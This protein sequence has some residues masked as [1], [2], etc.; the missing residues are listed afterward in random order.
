MVGSML[1]NFRCRIGISLVL[2]LIWPSLNAVADDF[3]DRNP[4]APHQRPAFAG[5]TRAAVI[6]DTIELDKTLIAKGLENP[7]GMAQL[8][9]GNWL[10]TER[11]GR[12]RYIT[13]TGTLF[14]P[15]TG[16]PPVDARGQGG[17]LDV[18][19]DADFKTSRR[20]WWSFA[21]PRGNGKNATAVASGILSDDHRSLSD[22]KVIFR[23]NPA[24]QSTYHFG[25]RLVFDKTG[26]L[27]ITTG[28][29]SYP[30]ARILAQD[31]RTHIGKV[32]RITKSGEAAPDNPVS[33]NF[34]PEI[35]SYG[36]RNIQAA[37]LDA[38]GRLWTVEHGPRG[39]DEL[40]RPEAHKNYGWPVITY[41]E[42][43]N[44]A[45]LGEGRTADDGMEQ[46]VYYWDP[47][48]APSGMAFY[49]GDM[50]P[51]W[52]GSALIGGLASRSLVRI[53]MKD[54]RVIGEA[55]Y[56]QGQARIRDVKIGQ[57]GAVYILSDAQNG[58]LI[59]LTPKNK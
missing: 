36:H 39:G 37:A 12:L 34:L 57:D 25:S 52:R 30:E 13:A 54:D 19:I 1:F 53:I 48:I 51:S 28:E 16:L 21:E 14:A 23:Q 41:G 22:V 7:W 20:L 15:I 44:G 50:F 31:T 3:N 32:I 17:L 18:V 58:A 11:A 56:L 2:G 40:N 47:V 29:R 8:A 59:R 5:Q 42:D 6:T 26:A 24:W 38:K 35:W 49:T 46:P 4:N 45:P 10:V 43:Y 27:F 33:A 9:N 55:R